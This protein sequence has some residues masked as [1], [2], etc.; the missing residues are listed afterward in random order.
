MCEF[1]E[2]PIKELIAALDEKEDR[3]LYDIDGTGGNVMVDVV[4]LQA[5]AAS[6]TQLLAAAKAL[7][8]AAGMWQS[9]V[10]QDRGC[11]GDDWSDDYA[12]LDLMDKAIEEAEKL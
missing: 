2:T 10:E 4:Q 7:K 11:S 8:D 9:T 6:H 12:V 1:C 5:L 3:H